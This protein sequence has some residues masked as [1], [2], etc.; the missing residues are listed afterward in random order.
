MNTPDFTTRE[1]R[2]R[3]E[4]VCDKSKPYTVSNLHQDEE[5]EPNPLPRWDRW[6]LGRV[7]YRCAK[8]GRER[9]GSQRES[10][11]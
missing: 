6:I 7:L 1:Q 2:E 10:W 11:L 9:I 3:W 4:N 5:V 8:C